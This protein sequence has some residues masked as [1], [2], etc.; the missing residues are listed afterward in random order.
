MTATTIG[1]DTGSPSAQALDDLFLELM[2][3]DEQLLLA[4]F[5]AIIAE[6]WGGPGSGRPAAVAAALPS[7]GTDRPAAGDQW[8]PAGSSARSRVDRVGR[9]RSP[10]PRHDCV[11]LVCSAISEGR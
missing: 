3:S 2:C 8:P 4:E 5:E 10:P 9:Q 11:P 6:A 7:A 1:P